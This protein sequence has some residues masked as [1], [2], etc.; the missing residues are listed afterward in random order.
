MFGRVHKPGILTLKFL[1]LTWG[2]ISITSTEG[3]GSIL[4]TN[5]GHLIAEKVHFYNLDLPTLVE[6]TLTI[7]S[8]SQ[9]IVT[10]GFELGD[11]ETSFVTIL[12][13]T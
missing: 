2:A 6:W 13:S 11:L 12:I 5:Y 9:C 3:G 1:K 7:T 4:V 10:N 8:Q